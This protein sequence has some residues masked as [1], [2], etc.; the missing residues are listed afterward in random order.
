MARFKP[1]RRKEKQDASMPRQGLPC[2]I[3]VILIIILTMTVMY[4]AI[5]SSA[6]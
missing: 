1:V 5:K 3:L 4:F 6:T 2:L